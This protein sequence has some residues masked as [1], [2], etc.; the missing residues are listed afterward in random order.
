MERSNRPKNIVW[1]VIDTLRADRLGC[2]GYFR[3]T[4]PTMDQLAREGV[5]FEDHTCSALS[6][7]AAFSCLLSGSALIL[8]RI[9]PTPCSS[10][11]CRRVKEGANRV[12]R[13]D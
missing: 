7:G 3:D 10:G 11:H 5:L 1:I 12:E 13:S 9:N 6:T 2:Y 4:S 8:A